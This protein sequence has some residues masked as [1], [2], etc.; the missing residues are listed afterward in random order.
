MCKSKLVIVGDS[1]F[2]QVAY[3]YFT[4]DSPYEVVAFSVEAAYLKKDSLFSL[5]IVA[6]ETLEARFS[7][8]NYAVYVAI[9]YT[10]FNRLRTRLALAVKNRG[11]ELASYIS[12]KASVWPNVLLGEHC[13][14][15]ENN[16][17][18]PFVSCGNNVVLWSGNHV[19]H[20]SV[21]GDNCFIAS[22][23]AIS[24]YV[25]IGTNSFL[26]VNA[27]IANNVKIGNDCWIGP[28]ALISKDVPNG[29]LY[30]APRSERAPISSLEFFKIKA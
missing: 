16:V 18:Q 23:V 27:T 13:F 4:H 29:S 2:A 5:P 26:G 12:T 21:I 17:I 19:G 15:F 6:L 10:Q 11:Y 1:A 28:G 24:G 9:P 20:H 3:E 25:E 30:R 14:V 8:D 7:P 22:Q